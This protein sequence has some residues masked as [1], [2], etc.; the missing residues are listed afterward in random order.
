MNTDLTLIGY[1]KEKMLLDQ[2]DGK[3]RALTSVH[4]MKMKLY[5]VADVFQTKGELEIAIGRFLF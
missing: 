2:K 5:V 1:T 3:Q 4:L